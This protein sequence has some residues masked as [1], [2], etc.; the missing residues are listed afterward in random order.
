[1]SVVSP[2]VVSPAV[3]SPAPTA[4]DRLSD[5]GNVETFFVQRSTLFIKKFWERED[6]TV[7]RR[8]SPADC[9]SPTVS[10]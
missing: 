4:I 3:V 7:S 5:V 6:P 8:L 1:M 9:L 10:R 2:V